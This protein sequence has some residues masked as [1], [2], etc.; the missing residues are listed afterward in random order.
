M[1]TELRKNG[2]TDPEALWAD[3]R[4][5]GKKAADQRMEH[6]ENTAADHGLQELLKSWESILDQTENPYG[7]P[8]PELLKETV[9]GTI[10]YIAPDLRSADVPR[11]DLLLFRMLCDFS[12]TVES[13]WNDLE[14][15]N[16]ILACAALT[17]YAIADMER[18]WERPDWDGTVRGPFTEGLDVREVFEER[19][20]R[21]SE[22]DRTDDEP[23]PPTEPAARDYLTLKIN[24]HRT[25]RTAYDCRNPYD[26]DGMEG[27]TDI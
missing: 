22:E 10:R 26:E 17:E 23:D 20:L 2:I 6:M 18:G 1:V 13:R 16:G 14:Y 12:S 24:C 9:Y 11:N 8:D 19:F 21:M 25:D 27:E 7:K 3:R 5:A 4:T 15:D